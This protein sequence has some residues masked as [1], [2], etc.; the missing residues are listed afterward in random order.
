M[1]RIFKRSCNNWSEFAKGRKITVDRVNTVEEAL[2]MCDQYNDSRTARQI[3]RGTKM[4][5]EKE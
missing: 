2:R 1:I 5:F 4:E 3:K